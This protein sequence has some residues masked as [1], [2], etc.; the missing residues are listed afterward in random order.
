MN[1]VL[2][3]QLCITYSYFDFE[4]GEIEV[5]AR[6]SCLRI[7]LFDLRKMKHC[8]RRVMIRVVLIERRCSWSNFKFFGHYGYVPFI[9]SGTLAGL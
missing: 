9:M 6:F 2:L 5:Y 3:R 1:R 4:V 7:L 8:F